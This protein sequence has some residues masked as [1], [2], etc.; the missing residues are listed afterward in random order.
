[1][2][3][4]AP[5]PPPWSFWFDLDEEEDPRTADEVVDSVREA[6]VST[7]EIHG[8]RLKSVRPEE[9]VTVAVDFVPRGPLVFHRRPARTLVI[10]VRKEDLDDRLAGKLGSEDFQTRVVAT[11]Y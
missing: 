1:V 4:L 2:P 5:P 9:S 10:R 6:V 7:L 11:E 3:D 8:A